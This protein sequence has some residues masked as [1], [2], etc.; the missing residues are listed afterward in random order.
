MQDML[1]KFKESATF[2]IM[3]LPHSIFKN[4]ILRMFGHKIGKKVKIGICISLRSKQIILQDGARIGN[5][6]VFRNVNLLHLSEGANIG[7]LNWVSSA[8]DFSKQENN[9]RLVL[10]AQSVIT[11]RHYL[12][13]SGSL[14]LMDGSAIWGVRSTVMTH[15]IDPHTWL[16]TAYKITIGNRSVIGSNSL[17]VP[18]TNLP[19]GCYFG[20]G[21]LISGSNYQANTK[22]VNKKAGPK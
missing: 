11:N 8:P 18:G 3:L 1:N 20:M 14:E 16:Q 13:V 9:A 6:N 7:N 5:L 21:S 10:H 15:G 19:Q 4:I 12:D 2:F 22:Y 17:I